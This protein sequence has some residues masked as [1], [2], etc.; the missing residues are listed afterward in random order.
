MYFL[1]NK[2]EKKSIK[3]DEFRIV[4]RLLD[5]RRPNHETIKTMILLLSFQV[6]IITVKTKIILTN[7]Q[8]KEKCSYCVTQ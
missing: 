6:D 4:V 8:I 7:F 2:A 5:K 3:V 1:M